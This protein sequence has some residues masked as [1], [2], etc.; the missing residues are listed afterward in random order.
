MLVREIAEIIKAPV[1]GTLHNISVEYLLTDSRSLIH[2]QSSV[3]FALRTKSGDGHLYVNDLYNNGLRVFVVEVVDEDSTSKYP[4]AVFLKVDNT[5]ASLQ[6]LAQKWR[7]KFEIPVIGIT[8][9][10][11]KTIVKEWLYQLLSPSFF[12]TRSPLSYNSQIGVPL[13]VWQLSEHTDIAIFEAGISQPDEM[14]KLAPIIAPTIGVLTNI[15]S[16]HQAAFTSKKQKCLEKLRLFSQSKYLVYSADDAVVDATIKD[17]NFDGELFSWTTQKRDASLH[18]S[19]VELSDKNTEVSFIFNAN[20]HKLILPFTDK[21]SV[22]NA[23]HCIAVCFVLKV[24]L[25]DIATRI[26]NLLPVAMR[27]EVIQGVR[28]CVLINDSY[29]SDMNSLELA[30]DFMA[31]RFRSSGAHRKVAILSDLEQTG[32]TSYELYSQVANLVHEREIDEVVGVGAGFVSA[33][34]LFAGVGFSAYATTDDLLKSAYLQHLSN[35]MILIKGARSACF[36]RVT[37]ALAHQLHATTLE[38]NLQAL[39]HN[40]RYYRSLLQPQTKMICMIKASAYGAGSVEVAKTLSDCGADYLAVAVADEGVA[41][42]LSGITKPIIV[43]NPESAAF[44]SMFAY[45]LEPEVYSFEILRQLS[46]AAQQA[47]VRDFPIHLK[48]DTGMSRLGFTPEKDIPLVVD[49]L[50]SQSSLKVN[51]VFTHFAGSDDKTFDEFTRQQYDRF[52]AAAQTLQSAFTHKILFHACNT[53]AIERFPDMHLDMVRLGL[54]LYGISPI[55]SSSLQPV[56]SLTTTILQIREVASDTTIGYSRR[57]KLVRPSRIAAL[58]IGYADG[59]NRHLGC[60][61]GYCIVNGQC[62]PYVG[63]ICM[64]VCMIDITDIHCNVGDRV[65][66]FGNNL[67]VEQIAEWLDTIPYEVLTHVSERVKRVYFE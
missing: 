48:L 12:V 49:I 2:P 36:E 24:P 8:G 44:A 15:G 37:K 1:L 56:A 41:L 18:F 57:G 47:G 32:L 6:T 16:A 51:S 27:L 63:N 4:D 30:F 21:V 28:D 66:V 65:E 43:M 46:D 13:S 67:P 10:N 22:Q 53:A 64:D 50:R 35:A 31:R 9:S 45:N 19:V 5:L 38:V 11:G 29:S 25:K 7:A 17:W 60:G 40:L 34:A 14:Q 39:A 59:L 58:P 55:G 33:S 23:L 3:F 61:R 20:Q 42:R 26:T 54:G 52:I 62:A